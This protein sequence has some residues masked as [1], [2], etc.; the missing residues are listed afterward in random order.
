MLHLDA[1]SILIISYA[2]FAV[3]LLVTGS[4][5]MVA[6]SI[7]K[8]KGPNG[9]YLG[10]PYLFT[11]PGQDTRLKAFRNI[12]GRMFLFTSAKDDPFL[13][14]I[15]LVFHWSLWIIIAAHADIVLYPYFTAAGI[16]ESTLEAIGA[17]LG[18]FFAILL[19]GSGLILFGRRAMDPYMRKISYASDY[20]AIL[21]IIAIGISGILMRFWLP[22]NFA[23]AQVSPFIL[24]LASFAPISAPAAGIFV[25][26][27]M[28][29]LTLFVYFPLSKL[30]HPFA[31]LTNPT[32][33]SIYHPGVIK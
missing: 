22:A 23:Y 11:Y 28:L 6:R 33:Y 24:S 21:L 17:Y 18:T 20:F 4:I 15:G 13:R 3:I 8:S 16:S 10:Y 32:L 19:V 27:F 31:F 2:Y 29:T 12:L 7:F 14:Y 26:H 25:T 1:L 5:F 30:L 9:T